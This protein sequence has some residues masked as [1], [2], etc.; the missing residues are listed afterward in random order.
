[1]REFKI[2]DIVEQNGHIESLLIVTGVIHDEERLFV[3]DPSDRLNRGL[4]FEI[5]FGEIT[6]H[7]REKKS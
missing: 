6:R 7:W 2:G 4:E 5:W 1:M 3:Q